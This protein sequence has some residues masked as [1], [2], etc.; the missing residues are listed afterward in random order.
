[1]QTEPYI[2]RLSFSKFLFMFR[3]SKG[4]KFFSADEESR[5][6]NAIVNA[7]LKT[8]GEIRIFIES[9]CRTKVHTRTIEIFKLLK[10]HNTIDRNGV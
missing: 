5:I 3:R 10:M 7:E 1:M 6:E 4:S 9:T 2:K 8:T